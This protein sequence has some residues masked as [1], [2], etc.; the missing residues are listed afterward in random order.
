M[1]DRGWFK[2][3]RKIFDNPLMRGDYLTLWIWLLSEASHEKRDSL[4]GG[5]RITLNPGQLTTGRKQMSTETGIQE[6]KIDRMIKTMICEQQIEQ[7][8][9]STNRLITITNWTKYQCFEQQNEQQVSNDC[10]TNEHT[11]RI[12]ELKNKDKQ[13]HK[14]VDSRHKDFIELF[15]KAWEANRSGGVGFK[16]QDFAQLSLML[17]RQPS[18]TADDFRIACRNCLLHKDFHAA[19][20]SLGY[21]A[22]Y[23]EKLIN[24]NVQ[25]PKAEEI[26][27]YG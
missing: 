14:P 8:T 10:T 13:P 2:L 7:Q 12:K 9:T 1:E 5:K 23:Y 24:L 22:S 19:N 11:Q 17:K 21:V 15:K 27:F 6:H 26:S 20:F 25:A 18:A 16:V 3:H 4:L